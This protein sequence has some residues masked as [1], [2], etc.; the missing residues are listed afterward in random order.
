[1]AVWRTS[2]SVCALLCV[3][4]ACTFNTSTN[5]QS[6]DDSGLP[7]DD[8]G[9]LDARSDA[10]AP[11]DC[12]S[13]IHIAVRVN[14]VSE[15]SGVGAPYVSSLVGD[16]VELSAE[17]TCTQSGIIE[18]RWVIEPG[19]TQVEDTALPNLTSET[20]SV[21]T[22]TP[23]QYTVRLEVGDGNRT[24]TIT[25]FAFQAHGFQ[26]VDSY[27]GNRIR[28]LSTGA[29]YLWVGAD[30]GGRRGLLVA[31]FSAYPLVNDLYPGD[32]LPSKLRVHETSGGDFVWFGSDD[33]DGRA[34]RLSLVDQAITSFPTITNGRTRD[35]D[36]GATGVR[37]AT[38]QGV[39]FAPDSETFE[40]ERD[41]DSR[42]VSYGPTG[43]WA[44]KND[45]YPLPDADSI[46]LFP[47]D[48]RIKALD[49]DGTLL[50]IGTGDDGLLT[51]ANGAVQSS[52]SE[53]SDDL[54]SDDVR[55][56]S[57]D[58]DLDIWIGTSS[59]A[60]RFKRDRNVWVHFD[61]EHGLEDADAEHIDTDMQSGRRAV[62]LGGRDGLFVMRV[63]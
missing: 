12:P 45:L 60:S 31:P 41:Q 5:A 39:A 46:S 36:E 10:I 27:D 48:D 30:N 13:E 9:M 53:E 35:I 26:E 57:V 43:A 37:F 56:V 21:Y 6:G 50:W 52:Y 63:P 28:G 29:D 14:D 62:Y 23:E 7:T 24:E 40:E 20:I 2:R 34:Y 11:E 8:G 44:G 3:A 58:D 16:T 49:D 55:A 42:A 1:M 59:G 47:G 61:G 19:T 17:G 38:N 51:F 33:A 54:P 22:T 25:I 15:P 4:G 32:S 18:Y